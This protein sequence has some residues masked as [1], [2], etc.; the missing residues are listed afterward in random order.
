MSRKPVL[1]AAAAVVVGVVALFAIGA[2][3]LSAR[4]VELLPGRHAFAEGRVTLE[5]PA[6]GT[7]V[8]AR[9]QMGVERSLWERWREEPAA[10]ESF[11]FRHVIVPEVGSVTSSTA[12]AESVRYLLEQ[13]QSGLVDEQEVR[14]ASGEP[15]TL[16]EVERAAQ[17]GASH[18][19]P[20][21]YGTFRLVIFDGDRAH[22]LFAHFAL[23]APEQRERARGLLLSAELTPGAPT[24]ALPRPT[25]P[26]PTNP[27][28]APANP[29]PAPADPGAR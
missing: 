10:W 25:A 3:W 19:G 17:D 29:A 26:L 24:T 5:L 7:D 9:T 6:G 8:T 22:E 27:A 11:G 15:A 28:P 23:D 14:I 4:D 16:L 21:S 18:S 2:L 13:G 1:V 20:S 12:D